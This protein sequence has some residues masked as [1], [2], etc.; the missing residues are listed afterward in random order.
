MAN[1][2]IEKIIAQLRKGELNILDI[3]EE[4]ENNPKIVT[5]ERELGL[6]ITGRRGYDILSHAF[7]AEEALA[8]KDQFGQ[9]QCR[10]I[11]LSFDTFDDYF[12]FLNGDIYDQSCYAFCPSLENAV[13]SRAID[14]QKLSARKSLIDNTI[15]NYTFAL[16]DAEKTHYQKGKHIHK[17]CQQWCEKFNNCR[18]YEELAKTVQK[19]RKSK[20]SHSVDVEFFF[21]Q[22]IMSVDPQD[23]QR[24]SAIMEYISSSEYQ[25]NKILN[26][27]CL[28][29]PPNAVVQSFHYTQASKATRYKYQKRLKD[30]VS[31]L[32]NGEIIWHRMADFDNS[33]YYYRE[34]ILGYH[35]DNP[36]CPC[37]K[38]YRYFDTF[39]EFIAY[40][41]GDLTNCDLSAAVEC[42]AN[43]SAYTVDET[44]ELPL[45]AYSE[46]AYSV[47]KYYCEGKFHVVQQWYSPAGTVLKEYH[48]T[49]DYFFDFVAFLNGDLS[50]ADL[51]LCDS[52]EFLEQWDGID[53]TN[54]KL[55][56]ILCKKFGQ[57]YDTLEI[58]RSLFQSFD[59]VEQN[60]V[61]TALMLQATRDL[62]AEAEQKGISAISMFWGNG[63]QQVHYISDLHLMHRIQHAQCRSRE[64]VHY[65]LQKI[66]DT[67]AGETGSLL[68][69]GGDVASDFGIFRMFAKLLSEALKRRNITVVFVL[70]NHELW[71]FPECSIEQVVSKYQEVLE[72]CGMYLLHNGLLYVEH[73]SLT[74]KIYVIPYQELCQMDQEQL[75]DR[76]RYAKN[77]ILGGLGF[78]GYNI[79]FNAEQGI[80]RGTVDRKT[81]IRESK[82]FEA[83][84]DRLHPVLSKKN[85]IILT[86]TPKKDWCRNAEPD[87]NYVYVSGHTHRNFF[88]DDGAYRIY[89]DN[90]VGYHQEQLHLKSFLLDS[91]YDCFADYEDGIF[92]ITKEQYVNFYRGKNLT[93]DFNR[94]A[95]V[96]YLLKKHGYYC[97]MEWYP[98]GNLMILN[99]AQP[100]KLEVQDLQYHY[101]N[102]DEM[103]SIIKAPL[104]SFTAY[105]NKI[106]AA[107][108]QIGGSGKIHGCIIDIDFFNH[109]YVNPISEDITGY[110]ASDIIHKIPYPSVPT[111]LENKCPELFENYMK[112]LKSGSEN[113]FA[114]SQQHDIAVLPKVYLDT[115]IYKASREIK[116]MQKISTNILDFW[117]EDLLLKSRENNLHTIPAISDSTTI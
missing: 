9:E 12:D 52:L 10:D 13:G 50:G 104:D 57:P 86:H 66:A 73:R 67:I 87:L 5:A 111:L 96:L 20:I 62:E 69:I 35:K 93:M 15:E 116:K 44:T 103:I 109:I 3:P 79:E 27:L 101:D 80:Y 82:R 88:Y 53:F 19:Y 61:E 107:I 112:Q 70:G 7:F 99:G 39:E 24:F 14:L 74:P 58:N 75:T 40:R 11:S 115:D 97:F 26:A 76:L 108:K 81:E 56:S 117:N 51:L 89:A 68:L 106:A 33:T 105:Q 55:K 32:E 4:H 21:Y 113:L 102:M 36:Y 85:T 41:N 77:V 90:Q 54:T 23:S 22:Y 83:L 1:P 16:T 34:Q 29:Y 98:S 2:D 71:S 25:Q 64:D 95:N 47:K 92:E 49:F 65:L 30:F 46:P 48:H 37:V 84:Y 59:C 17:A 91:D 63:C 78:S 94:A 42:N 45:H 100:K 38:L 18:S 110:W 114:I 8:Y 43:F 6:R 31:W 72:S 60:E 28:V